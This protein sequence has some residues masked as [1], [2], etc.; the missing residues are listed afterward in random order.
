MDFDFGEDD[1]LAIY[2]AELGITVEEL[3]E[4]R[5]R[6]G[7]TMSGGIITGYY[8]QFEDENPWQTMVKIKGL[9][10]DTVY[11]DSNIF[12]TDDGSE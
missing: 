6:E 1:K 3:E 5:Y 10:G 7:E 11:L 12:D 4:L 8:L 2:A 9:Q